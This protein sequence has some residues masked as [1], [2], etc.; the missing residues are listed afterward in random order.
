MRCEGVL[1]SRRHFDQSKRLQNQLQPT[2]L[3]NPSSSQ[4]CLQSRTLGSTLGL[5][6]RP[7][8]THC[9]LIFRPATWPLDGFN[10]QHNVCP[11]LPGLRLWKRGIGGAGQVAIV[12]QHRLVR[13][14][15][16]H[17]EPRPD[18]ILC[19]TFMCMQRNRGGA[20]LCGGS[21]GTECLGVTSRPFAFRCPARSRGD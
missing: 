7:S 8:R 9:L 12:R 11:S 19:M 4:L 2:F 5:T 16:L 17:K 1:R 3:L 10:K 6:C 20:V 15:Q 21:L 18:P 13:R 14:P